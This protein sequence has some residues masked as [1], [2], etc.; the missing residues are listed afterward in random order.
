M[1]EGIFKCPLGEIACVAEDIVTTLAAV[2]T[3]NASGDVPASTRRRGLIEE[4]LDNL[5][6]IGIRMQS[7]IIINTGNCTAG[8]KGRLCN[9]CED[10][11]AYSESFG[12]E[13]CD[14][15]GAEASVYIMSIFV[16]VS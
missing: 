4:D 5:I 12:C 8:H 9:T 13:K 1:S 15:S 10:G 11:Y 6:A 7:R 14:A 2:G 3:I 16:V